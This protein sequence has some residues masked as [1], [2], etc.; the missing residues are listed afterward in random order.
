MSFSMRFVRGFFGALSLIS[1]S[2]IVS[3]K[4]QGTN[5]P[6]LE[7]FSSPPPCRSRLRISEKQKRTINVRIQT[8]LQHKRFQITN[9]NKIT[10]TWYVNNS[11]SVHFKLLSFMSRTGNFGSERRPSRIRDKEGSAVLG[12]YHTGTHLV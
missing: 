6:Y 2:F 1:P 7:Y 4:R 9:R 5:I 8:I 12:N 11:I 3:I 10:F